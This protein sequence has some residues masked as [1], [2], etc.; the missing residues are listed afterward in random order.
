MTKKILIVD[1]DKDLVQSLERVFKAQGYEVAVAYRATEGL[2]QALRVR[3]DLIVLDVTMETDTAGFEF[4]YQLRSRREDSRYRELSEVPIIMLTAI[5]QVTHSRFS[6]DERESFL[7]RVQAFLT[8][9]LRVDE[10]V[11]K[12]T[13]VI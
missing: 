2:Q 5:H 9:P 13:E 7:P 3:P 10:L 4:V 11:R 8:K 1:D 12:V 6:L